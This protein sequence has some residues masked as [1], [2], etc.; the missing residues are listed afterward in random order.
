MLT[1]RYTIGV[2]ILIGVVAVA[3]NI[4]FFSSRSCTAKVSNTATKAPLIEDVDEADEA[5]EDALDR[6]VADLEAVEL[7]DSGGSG[8]D[9]E[10]GRCPFLKTQEIE[11]AL[12][13]PVEVWV[14]ESGTERAFK[15]T[16][17]FTGPRGKSAIIDGR[18][19]NE[20]DEWDGLQLVSVGASSVLVSVGDESKVLA[21]DTHTFQ[22][23]NHRSGEES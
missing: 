10:W 17:I 21:L 22:I 18:L 23:E 14:G 4:I 2:L 20:G 7:V 11:S 16:G 9:G 15:L 5:E 1:N 8:K 12:E 3:Y 6:K 13:E 19:L